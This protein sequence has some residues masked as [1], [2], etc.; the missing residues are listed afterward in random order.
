MNKPLLI[1]TDGYLSLSGNSSLS[2]SVDGYLLLGITPPPTPIAVV[3]DDNVH[4]GISKG[5]PPQ[6]LYL[7]EDE[8]DIEEFLKIFVQCLN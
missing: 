6:V 7:E 5:I 3:Q 1:S 4:G 8:N 2:I